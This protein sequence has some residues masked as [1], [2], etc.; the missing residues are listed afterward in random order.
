LSGAP[1]E[2]VHE[3]GAET[4]L[5]LDQ[6]RAV[7]NDL[8]IGLLGVGFSPNWSFPETPRMPKQRYD[9]MRRYMPLVGSRGL[10]MMYLTAPI[11]VNLDFAD[12]ADMIK[13]LRVSLAL[14]PI[15]TAIFAC[16]PFAERHPSGYLSLRSS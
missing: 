2:T 8:G 13:K 12:E 4:Q 1:L 6:V 16:S 15:A 3:L 9:V 10:D 7:G 5:H 11:Q 14:Q